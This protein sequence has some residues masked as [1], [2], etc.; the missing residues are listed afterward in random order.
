M[1]INGITV[2]QIQIKQQCNFA[3][4]GDLNLHISLFYLDF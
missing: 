4:A 2:F 1:L 3:F